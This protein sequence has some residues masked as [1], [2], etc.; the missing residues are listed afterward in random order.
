M[1]SDDL[2]RH[3]APGPSALAGAAGRLG[4]HLATV[5]RRR[6][7]G[8]GRFL[9][10]PLV[11]HVL[12]VG[13]FTAWA[14]LFGLGADSMYLLSEFVSGT[15][16]LRMQLT[17]VV[18]TAAGATALC[19]RRRRPLVVAAAM[20]VLAMASL[21]ATG[22]THGFEL[23]IAIA[24]CSV[25]ATRPVRYAWATAAAVVLPV[26]AV[27]WSSPLV[28]LVGTRVLGGDPDD[29]AD[30]RSTL[31][32]GSLA[33]LVTPAWAVTAVP[34]VVLALIGVAW[35]ALIR[36]RRLRLAA[37]AEAAQARAA[38]QAQRAR[39]T[40]ADERARVAR[41]MHDVVAH[42][43]TV[44]VALGGGAAA[45][46][47]RAPEQSRLALDELV[48]TGRTALDDVR[49]IL[50]VLHATE[51]ADLPMEP[52][53]DAADLARLVERFRTAGLPVRTRGLAV[54]GL[55]ALDTTAQLAVFRIVQE[56][57]TNSLRHAPGTARVDVDVRLLPDA[58]EVVVTDQGPGTGGATPTPGTRRGLVGMTERAAAFG[59]TVEA[60]PYG[61]GWRVRALLP[62]SN[63]GEA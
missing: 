2:V 25:A 27:A 20:G 60:G 31:L 9:R 46:L 35:G 48:E 51:D 23:G 49:R 11:A 50:G 12:V 24:L 41:E 39:L 10:R 32:P 42:S 38:E 62:Q 17:S 53:P 28:R 18:L 4:A 16:V 56:S 37:L 59:G 52:Q 63:E 14:L 3:D 19:W 34:V 43:I 15:Q 8:A 36:T 57:L 6:G 21:L 13:G 5:A 61:Q 44:M 54:T 26:L 55:D 30:L 33:D 40:Q 29:P 22:A 1:T 58:V 47:D 7:A 45:A